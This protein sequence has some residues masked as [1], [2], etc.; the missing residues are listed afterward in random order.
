MTQVLRVV[1]ASDDAAKA[2]KLLLIRPEWK[3]RC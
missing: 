3:V 2:P 1:A